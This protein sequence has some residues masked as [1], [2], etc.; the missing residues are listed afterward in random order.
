MYLQLVN[1]TINQRNAL[2]DYL[3]TPIGDWPE[4]DKA[5]RRL[6]G[7][8]PDDRRRN[9][10]VTERNL[11]RTRRA[12]ELVRLATGCSWYSCHPSRMGK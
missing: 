12:Q 11:S 6:L 9:A 8:L 4:T 1:L 5:W 10:S 3:D 2:Q 7:A